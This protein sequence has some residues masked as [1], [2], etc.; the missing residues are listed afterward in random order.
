MLHLRL[1][2]LF[3]RRFSDLNLLSTLG[4][5]FGRLLPLVRGP[6]TRC[7]FG[8]VTSTTAITGLGV[9]IFAFPARSTGGSVSGLPRRRTIPK[10]G[11]RRHSVG[12]PSFTLLALQSAKINVGDVNAN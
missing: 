6:G 2:G 8:F 5:R 1:G 4:S 3:R 10:L 7:L 11:P 9:G 12:V